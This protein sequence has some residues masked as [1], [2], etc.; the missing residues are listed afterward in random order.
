MYLLANFIR[1]V[2]KNDNLLILT[3]A[4]M[5]STKRGDFNND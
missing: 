2:A 4:T 3:S 5:L 1:F